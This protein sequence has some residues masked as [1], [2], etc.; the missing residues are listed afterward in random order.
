VLNRDLWD[1]GSSAKAVMSS[2]STDLI[3]LDTLGKLYR[4]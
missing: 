1:I 2:P 4:D 3:V